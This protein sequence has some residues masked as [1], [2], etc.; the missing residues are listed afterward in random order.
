LH[1]LHVFYNPE[2][3]EKRLMP[4]APSFWHRY[5]PHHEFPLS[6][7]SSG[8][9]HV[10][11]LGLLVL[12]GILAA[13]WERENNVEVD[14]IVIAG[15]GGQPNGVGTQTTGPNL[16]EAVPDPNSLP[17][18]QPKPEVTPPETLKTTDTSPKPLI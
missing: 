16:H 5:S 14:A 12:G 3:K 11:V 1:V 8:V 17:D 10:T 18:N 6:L 2:R 7:S 13:R 9:A 15:G 4:P